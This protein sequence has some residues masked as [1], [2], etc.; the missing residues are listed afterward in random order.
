MPPYFKCYLPNRVGK[1]KLFQT[2]FKYLF[3]V[4]WFVWNKV[5]GQTISNFS[6]LTT[7]LF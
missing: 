1:V 3:T 2:Q 4:F 6:Q 5:S 7:D